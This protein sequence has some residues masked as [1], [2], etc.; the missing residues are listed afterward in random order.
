MAMKLDASPTT[1]TPE[2]I[3]ATA[4][5]IGNPMASTEPNARIRITMAN[6]SP[7]TSDSGGWNS[8]NT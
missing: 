6:P 4:I 1:I 8:A 7:S 3:P 2:A 5:P